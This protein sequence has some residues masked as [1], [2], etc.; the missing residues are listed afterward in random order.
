MSDEKRMDANALAVMLVGIATSRPTPEAVDEIAGMLERT[1][2]KVNERARAEE[3][4]WQRLYEAEVRSHAD[5]QRSES[6]LRAEAERLRGLVGQLQSL[7]ETI[8]ADGIPEVIP[9]GRGSDRVFLRNA[10]GGGVN[11]LYGQQ[12]DVAR[13]YCALLAALRAA[14]HP[15]APTPATEAKKFPPHRPVGSPVQPPRVGK[16]RCCWDHENGVDASRPCGPT[17]PET[18]ETRGEESCAKAG[19]GHPMLHHEKGG[20]C[21]SCIGTTRGCRTSTR[22]EES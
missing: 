21:W 3:E 9:T 16:M 4:R 8:D 17:P 6:A 2:G 13:A 10:P 15:S 22:G 12:E 5:T 7:R 20:A 14:L 1:A 11:I 18:T 19:C